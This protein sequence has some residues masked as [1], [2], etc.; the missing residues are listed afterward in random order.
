MLPQGAPSTAAAGTAM[1]HQKHA[2]PPRTYSV[3][4]TRQPSGTLHNNMDESMQEIRQYIADGKFVIDV[5]QVGACLPFRSA[6]MTRGG[7]DSQPFQAN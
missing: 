1:P 2:H 7:G 3:P 5:E 4:T 6:T